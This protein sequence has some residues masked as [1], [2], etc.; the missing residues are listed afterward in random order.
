MIAVIVD[1]HGFGILHY[2]PDFDV[3]AAHSGLTCPSI[4]LAPRG[5]LA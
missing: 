2:D 5:S 1:H 4:W 3:I